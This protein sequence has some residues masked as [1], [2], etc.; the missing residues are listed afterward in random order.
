MTTELP[1]GPWKT[2]SPYESNRVDI[3][4]GGYGGIIA[5]DVYPA[6][7]DLLI[8]A[9]RESDPTEITA[10]WLRSVGFVDDGVHI[11]MK[12]FGPDRNGMIQVYP[13]EHGGGGWFVNGT[14]IW[15]PQ[16]RGDVR[17]MCAALGVELKEGPTE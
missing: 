3:L 15:S 4:C 7:A 6:V 9:E 14:R 17:R 12:R 8:R 10:D 13:E 1:P 2:H 5:R 11:A 16:S